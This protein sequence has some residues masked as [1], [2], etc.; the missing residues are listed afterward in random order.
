M[1]NDNRLIPGECFVLCDAGDDT[2]NVVSYR[3]DSIEPFKLTRVSGVSEGKYGAKLIDKEFL[4]WLQQRLETSDILAQDF[5]NAGDGQFML[6]PKG[7]I[8]LERFERPKHVFSGTE[9][10]DISIPRGILV[11]TGQQSILESGSIS[12]TET[13]LKR[14]FYRS[15]KGTVD[16][17]SKQVVQVENLRDGETPGQVTN[18]FLS[19][20]FSEIGYL[21]NEVKKFADTCCIDVKRV[22]DCWSGV[23]Q[24][25]V[26]KG[27][28]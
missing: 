27:W 17:I 8:L 24:G 15:V 18:I 28:Q 16:L 20:S 7:R 10:S 26:L 3:V 21:F 13:D 14:F 4:K 9:S 12:L 25:A 22:S 11:A 5:G 23:V 6:V 1:E 19:G 2:V